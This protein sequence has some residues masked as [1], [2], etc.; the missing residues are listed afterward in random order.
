M[1]CSDHRDD[2]HVLAL[3]DAHVRDVYRYVHR[4]CLDHSMAEDV[5][6]DVFVAALREA[7]VVV[8]VGWLMRS[9]RNRLID[10]IRREANYRDKLLVLT[11]DLNDQA[12]DESGALI[13][14]LRMRNALADLRP[15]HRIS[16][17]LHYV[18]G[19]SVAELAQ[20]LGRS[21]RGAEGL[22]SR[23]RAALRAEL[24]VGQ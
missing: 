17:M 10:I 22:L 14:S 13:E 4:M 6:Q 23:A 1:T 18:D 24:E 7:N 2:K 21:Y 11:R 12:G 9:A 16:L 5:T 19:C 15:D 8:S 3:Y 20:A